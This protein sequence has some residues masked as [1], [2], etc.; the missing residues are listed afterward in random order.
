MI[1]VVCVQILHFWWQEVCQL[2]VGLSIR[3]AIPQVCNCW[4]LSAPTTLVSVSTQM[5]GLCSCLY[6][7]RTSQTLTLWIST[8][9]DYSLFMPQFTRVEELGGCLYICK[10]AFVSIMGV[11]M[12]ILLKA[13][14]AD[15]V[16]TIIVTVMPVWSLVLRLLCRNV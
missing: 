16:L 6:M 14:H 10:S 9:H 11:G 8:A 1:F 4:Q 12:L 7:C 3:A 15:I 13:Q 2:I 5:Y